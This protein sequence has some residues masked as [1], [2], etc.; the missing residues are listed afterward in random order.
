MIWFQDPSALLEAPSEFWPRASQS[1]SDKVNA[2]SRF[3]IYSSL[4]A[5]GFKKDPKILLL[6]VLVLASIFFYFKLNPAH[7]LPTMNRQDPLNNFTDDR[8][9]DP[10][11]VSQFMSKVFPDDK[12]NAERG[13]FTMPTMD[14]E[15]YMQIQ[16]RGQPMCRDDQ[17]ACTPESNMHF[18]L[19][20]T[21]RAQ[22]G[23]TS[24]LSRW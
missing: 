6:G 12:R 2:T 24:Q 22:Y 7:G 3:I 13:F 11:N 8:V 18:P 19:E 16:G 9:Y 4:I 10:D 21:I 17:S 20:A 15:P 14:L 1:F 5:F 23:L